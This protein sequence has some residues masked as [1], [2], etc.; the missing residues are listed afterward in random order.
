MQ[1]SSC[2]IPDIMNELNASSVKGESIRIEQQYLG[3]TEV[4]TYRFGTKFPNGFRSHSVTGWYS[5]DFKQDRLY[6]TSAELAKYI[7][8]VNSGRGG[9][10]ISYLVERVSPEHDHASRSSSTN[11]SLSS[12][13]AS[14]QPDL[15]NTRPSSPKKNFER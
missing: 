12:I 5:T 13:I 11:P 4:K 9:R 14:A 15:T 8:A 7:S 6:M 1:I 10:G 3:K 2:S